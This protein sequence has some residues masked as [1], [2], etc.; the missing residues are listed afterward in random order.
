MT[1][2]TAT[3]IPVTERALIARINR[4]LQREGEALKALR[5]GLARRDLGEF[6]VLGAEKNRIV[7]THVS[8]ETLGR[9]LDALAPW[10]AVVESS[11]A[12]EAVSLGKPINHLASSSGS[13]RCPCSSTSC[14]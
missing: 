12:V 7:K 5:G 9:E 14:R 2:K 10:E 8:P 3:K 11:A 1:T 13:R 4:K 6:Y